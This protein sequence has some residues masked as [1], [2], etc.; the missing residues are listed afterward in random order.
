MCIVM[1]E[2]NDAYLVH[3]AGRIIRMFQYYA[4]NVDPASRE[5]Q[6]YITK[7]LKEKT[8]TNAAALP[9]SQLYKLIKQGVEEYLASHQGSREGK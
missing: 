3:V 7:Y 2:K 4:E 9:Y 8:S 1:A 5:F 6:E